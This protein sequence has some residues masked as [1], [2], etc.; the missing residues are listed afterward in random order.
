MLLSPDSGNFFLPP[1]TDTSV[2]YATRDI[3]VVNDYH[4]GDGYEIKHLPLAKQEIPHAPFF[5]A[6]EWVRSR[7]PGLKQFSPVEYFKQKSEF[8]LVYD[9]SP[10]PIV[11][12]ANREPI[13][14]DRDTGL[15]IFSEDSQVFV[16]RHADQPFVHVSFDAGD[17]SEVSSPLPLDTALLIRRA[18]EAHERGILPAREEPQGEL[19][20]ASFLG[21]LALPILEA[22]RKISPKN[23]QRVVNL[24]AIASLLT[25]CAGPATPTEEMPPPPSGI[26]Q[27]PPPG[28]TVQPAES[29]LVIHN[30]LQEGLQYG[31][32]LDAWLAAHTPVI[33]NDCTLTDD[34]TRT[35][36]P[37][38]TF[39]AIDGLR[40][41]EVLAGD[42]L[43]A[44][45]KKQPDHLATFECNIDPGK[46]V[47]VYF[48]TTTTAQDSRVFV[49]TQTD[50]L[51]PGVIDAAGHVT[52]VFSGQEASI[53]GGSE[54][55]IPETVKQ[56]DCPTF[57]RTDPVLSTLSPADQQNVFDS[58]FGDE[59]Q[60]INKSLK[61]SG[62]DLSKVELVSLCWIDR[63]QASADS[64]NG[65]I[66]TVVLSTEHTAAWVTQFADGTYPD[67]PDYRVG[68]F[69]WVEVNPPAGV[70]GTLMGYFPV[71]AENPK[72]LL[73]DHAHE[74]KDGDPFIARWDKGK[75]VK[76]DGTELVVNSV[77]AV[78]AMLDQLTTPEL[79]KSMEI[80][81]KAG[82]YSWKTSLSK[83]GPIQSVSFGDE[84][85]AQKATFIEFG[86]LSWFAYMYYIPEG[87]NTKDYPEFGGGY[88]NAHDVLGGDRGDTSKA[89]TLMTIVDERLNKLGLPYTTSILDLEGKF[90]REKFYT[91]DPVNADVITDIVPY[92]QPLRGIRT[93]LVL[94]EEFKQIKS[95]LGNIPYIMI[96]SK[97]GSWDGG[98][99]N[100]GKGDNESIVF[101]RGDKLVVIEHN[102]IKV[103]NPYYGGATFSQ[104]P[105]DA[106][107]G[108]SDES[109]SAMA[110]PLMYDNFVHPFARI[111]NKNI[112]HGW[113]WGQL[114]YMFPPGT[115]TFV[116]NESYFA[117]K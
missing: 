113:A 39:V 85:S 11:L 16:P 66:G 90:K 64:P 45:E 12:Y 74:T 43:A 4:D 72:I 38:D 98:L 52:A 10:D 81:T 48:T 35:N 96:S 59:Q 102:E 111:V 19:N 9:A 15:P 14:Y 18:H 3:S 65:R 70:D 34:P 114:Y 116:P 24:V 106:L 51:L 73:V 42:A 93:A 108:L 104:M 95:T 60:S 55:T 8:P 28:L 67:R 68:D 117:S 57:I 41:I 30:L 33:Q 83:K 26:T 82:R 61:A 77:E 21:A 13:A 40:Q 25:A 47:D 23:V 37:Y 49:P 76:P 2:G 1:D 44:V 109:T 80:D 115:V 84:Y 5:A 101:L 97:E 22:A 78:L 112:D 29:A 56:A 71:G 32:K 63:S 27:P 94:F 91:Y 103:D 53:P 69:H 79:T 88:T 58:L 100:I 46:Q 99:L 89:D 6:A 36:D 62:V 105:R 50:T 107:T 87:L 31:P 86:R 20:A 110:L 75:W 54:G 7:H 17:E 92:G